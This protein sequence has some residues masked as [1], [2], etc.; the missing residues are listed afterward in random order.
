VACG[1]ACRSRPGWANGMGR[2]EIC[3]ASGWVR[4]KSRLDLSVV[5]LAPTAAH[6]PTVVLHTAPPEWRCRVW[7]V[8]GH[9]QA[10]AELLSAIAQAALLADWLQVATPPRP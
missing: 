7:R 10:P 3:C 9:A 6:R 1:A 8:V 5:L 4:W 2:A